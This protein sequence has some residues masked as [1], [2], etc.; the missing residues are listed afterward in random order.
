[1]VKIVILFAVTSQGPATSIEFGLALIE[2][3][4]DKEKAN[5]V[6]IALVVN[7]NL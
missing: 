7:N 4:V 3:L 5:E 6:G 1:M 2:L